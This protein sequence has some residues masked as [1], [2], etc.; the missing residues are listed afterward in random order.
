[1]EVLYINVEMISSVQKAHVTG[2]DPVVV[3]AANQKFIIDGI[4]WV[5]AVKE[6][7]EDECLW[8]NRTYNVKQC[9][10]AVVVALHDE[11][12]F[13]HTV[14]KNFGECRGGGGGSKKFS[15]VNWILFGT[16][17]FVPS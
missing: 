15:T 13:D 1:M 14:H 11:N 8:K 17:Q 10:R 9:F 4:T 6:R 5:Y 7:M 12:L 16:I 2:E 3:P